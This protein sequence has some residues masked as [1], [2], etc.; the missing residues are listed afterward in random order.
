MGHRLHQ[1][2]VAGEG[3]FDQ[4]LPIAGDRRTPDGD[5]IPAE[6]VDLLELLQYDGHGV[7]QIGVVIGIQQP[8]VVGDEG[9]LG[10]GGAGVDAQPGV[11]RIGAHV[12]L[13]GVH[14][15]MARQKGVVFRGVGE[16]GRHRVHQAHVVHALLQLFQQRVKG[17]LGVIGGAQGRA[18]ACEAV[19]VLRKNRVL[20]VQLQGLHKAFPQTHEKVQRPAQKDDLALE[21]AALG[22]AGHRLVH[23]GLENGGRHVLLPSALVEDGLDVALGEHAAAGG[24]GVDL[25]VLQAQ[26]VQLVHAYV[27]Q[28]GH[29][30]DE[31]PGAAGAG[32]V[33]PLLQRA[34]EKDDLGILA[35]QLDDGVG[36]RY[37]LVDSSGGGVHLLHKVDA[38][39]L[40]HAQTGGT[41]NDHAHLLPGQL[42]PDG[43]QGLDGALPGLGVMPLIGAEQQL[44]LLVQHHHLHGGG[45]DINSNAKAHRF[46]L[47]PYRISYPT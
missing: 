22:Q 41:G 9:H 46:T 3:V 26:R 33:H 36:A 25:L 13:G 29:L 19:A 47:Y 7:A 40:G 11:A 14:G 34:A 28:G 8:A 35:A 38:R 2:R 10:G 39:R 37:V 44:V 31:R 15:V 20:A 30:V 12:H 32:A 6:P 43:A 23:H 24:D 18:D 5:P 42:V 4:V 21:L 17:M 16:E 45:A 27:H 1:A